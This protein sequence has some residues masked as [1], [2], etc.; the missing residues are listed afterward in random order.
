[1]E[2]INLKELWR[3][4]ISKFYII[5][6]VVVGC[7]LV[8]NIYLAFFQVPLYESNTSLIFANEKGITQSDINL[9]K[10]LISTYNEFIKS[11]KVLNQVIDNLNLKVGYGTLSKR[12]SATAVSDTQLIRI[13]VSD[14]SPQTARDIANEISKVFAKEIAEYY[15]VDNISVVDALWTFGS[16]SPEASISSTPYN[17]NATKQN[18]I[19]LVVGFVLGF[20][21]IFISFYFDTSVKDIKTI[22]DKLNLTVLGTVPKV[23]EKNGY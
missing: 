21:I 3:Y 17:I 18:V 9:N 11:K 2:E 14:E 1:M 8:G 20:A 12:V 15:K 13:V 4:F 10:S 22:E 19:Y 5:L 23:G 7:L 16:N 6:M